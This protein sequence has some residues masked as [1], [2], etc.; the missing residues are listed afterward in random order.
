MILGLDRETFW[1]LVRFGAAFGIGWA[2]MDLFFKA[3]SL[4]VRELWKSFRW[5]ER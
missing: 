4:I 5:K 1:H 3:L 2:A